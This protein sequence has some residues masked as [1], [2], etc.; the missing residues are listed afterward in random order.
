MPTNTLTLND[1]TVDYDR[2]GNGPAL[3]LIPGGVGHGGVFD[4]FAAHLA[5]H[6]DVVSMSSRVA[7][8][9][10][11]VSAPGEQRPADHAQDA[12]CLI[13]AL[14][15]E[16]PVV[17][18]FSSGAV[19]T[20][21][22]LAGHPDHVRTAV[23]HEPPLVNLLPDAARHRAALESVRTAARA[24]DLAEAE[25]LMFTAMTVP[26]ADTGSA[27]L[28]HTGTWLDGYADTR[29]EPPGPALVELFAVLGGLK[30][31]MLEHI[32]LPFTTHEPDLAALEAQ[33]GRLV[34]VAGIDS[35]GQL[36]YRSA[37]AL[38]TRL[39]LP[40]TELPGGHLGPIERPTQ[41]A[42]AFRSLLEAL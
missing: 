40:L 14:F 9:R 1:T 19:T 21:E 12:R 26:G 34:P 39:G 36:P 37:A 24:Q 3:L 41:F 31:V 15:D 6:Y 16:P 5:D 23:V 8:T 25:A 27:E 7:S 4:R 29:P 42:T 20:V 11:P 33:T 22:L 32:L 13:D 35:R 30:P 38:A 2:R 28:R 17:F 18:G 10:Q